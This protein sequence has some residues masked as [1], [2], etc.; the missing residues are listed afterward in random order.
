MGLQVEV[1][2]MFR[3]SK[4]DPAPET[5]KPGLTF[6][7]TK[8]NLRLYPVGLPIILLTDD[9][10]AIGNCVVKSAEMHAKGMNLEVEIIT[11]FDD[12]E[13]KIHTQKVIEA[14]TQT[15]YLPRK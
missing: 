13:S 4:D 11:K 3:R 2:T 12:T 15:G 6:R 14:L 7:T 5:L 1:N 8:T 9:W 10:I